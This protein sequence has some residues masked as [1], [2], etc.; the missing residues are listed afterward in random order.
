M[1]LEPEGKKFCEK[2]FLFKQIEIA[3]IFK[4]RRIADL[5]FNLQ[6]VGVYA[7]IIPELI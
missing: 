4:K 1:I 5:C 3:M 2:T 7:Y 6:S